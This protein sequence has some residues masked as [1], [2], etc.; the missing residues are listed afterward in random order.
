VEG[1]ETLVIINDDTLTDNDA[2]QAAL[3]EV[4]EATTAIIA[5]NDTTGVA[6]LWWYDADGSGDSAAAV[7]LAT[8]ENITTVGVLEGF[9][10]ANFHAWT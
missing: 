4:N 2:F 5:I 8:F 10:D 1:V 6:E 3:N 7:K 9:T